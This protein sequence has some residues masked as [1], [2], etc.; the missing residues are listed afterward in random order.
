VPEPPALYL[1]SRSPRRAQLLSELGVRFAIVD[2][3]VP[4]VPAPRQ[5]PRAYALEIAVAK[6]QAGRARLADD[7][8][9]LGADTDVSIDGEIL[10]K[11]L[12]REQG[13]AMLQRLSARTHLVCSA[14][15]VAG[16]GR[17]ET[18]V[19]LT[20]VEF[21]PISE[22]AAQAYW[23]SGEPCDKAGG[24][25]IQGFAARWVRA[26]H[27]SYSGVVGLPLVETVELLDRFGIVS[28]R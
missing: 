3:P 25:A 7:R 12:D 19:T 14:V 8:P 21:S 28:R 15:A 6:A 27:G 17:L 11:P 5:D 10:G 20:E 1:A 4:E 26:V 9:V 22:R 18:A 23:D 24:Y 2:A 13:V 16:A